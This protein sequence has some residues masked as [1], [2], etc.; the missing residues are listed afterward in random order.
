MDLVSLF[1]PFSSKPIEHEDRLTWAFLVTCK[2]NPPL[3]NFLRELVLRETAESELSLENKDVIDSWKPA[4]I[5]TQKKNIQIESAPNSIVSVLL[6]DKPIKEKI[7]VAWSDR[8]PIYDGIIEYSNGLILIIEN[9]LW[10]GNVWRDQLSPNIESFPSELDVENSLHNQAVCLV[11]SEIL[12]GVLG[13]INSKYATF[14]SSEIASDFLTFVEEIHPELT[15]YRTF[16]LCAGRPEA[17]RI[18]KDKLHKDIVIVRNAD[19]EESDCEFC[20]DYIYRKDRIAERIY[21]DCEKNQ[22]LSVLS[23]AQR[24]LSRRH[25]NSTIISGK[26][27]TKNF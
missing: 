15:P 11:W 3:Q 27:E 12:E 8:K 17:L 5:S 7:N 13:F 21:F 19:G 26:K 10:H 4:N 16:K 23:L 1:N 2:Y 9:K 24:T 20:D 14:G 25:K 6:T 22:H 18:R